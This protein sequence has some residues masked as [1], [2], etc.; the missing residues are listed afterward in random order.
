MIEVKGD[1]FDFIN[2]EGVDA[3]CITTNGVVGK[4]GRNPMGAGTAGEA[5]RRWL[6]IRKIVGNNIKLLG[7]VPSIIGYI[8]HNGNYNYPNNTTTIGKENKCL[9][10]SFPSKDHFKNPSLPQLIKSSAEHLVKLT[11]YHKLRKVI[12]PAPGVG[13]FTGQLNWEKD[14]KPMIENILD[15]RFHITF[16]DYK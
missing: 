10:I 2:K 8:D 7:N 14:V 12:I 16:L 6:D 15:D 1:I 11:D 5:A 13:A 3:I 9:I 4:D